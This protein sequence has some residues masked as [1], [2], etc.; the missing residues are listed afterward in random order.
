MHSVYQYSLGGNI[1]ITH[2]TWMG[3]FLMRYDSCQNICIVCVLMYIIALI[4]IGLHIA[5]FIVLIVG[6]ERE[7]RVCEYLLDKGGWGN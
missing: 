4:S 7:G 3:R 5:Y 2:Q 6:G 1:T